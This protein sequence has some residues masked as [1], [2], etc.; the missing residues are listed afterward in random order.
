TDPAAEPAGEGVAAEGDETEAAA[1]PPPV[2]DDEPTQDCPPCKGGAPGWMAT[3]ADMATLLMSFF[4]LLLSFS[5][6]ELPKFEQINGSIKAAFGVKR[7]VPTINIP[8][9]RS[10]I[11]ENFSPALAQRTVLN[12]QQQ[13]AID[14]NAEFLIR[15]TRE[16]P[17]SSPVQADFE[18]VQAALA[19]PIERGEVQV[20]VEDETIVVEYTA[21]SSGGGAGGTGQQQATGGKLSQQLVEVA[22][23]VTQVQSEVVSE[24]QLYRLSTTT[25]AEELD[26]PALDTVASS[27]TGQPADSNRYNEI[28]AALRSEVEQ[29]LVEVEKV[30]DDV[31][32]RLASQG[33][34]LSGSAELDPGFLPLLREVGSTLVSGSGRVRVEGHTDN[35]PVAFSQQFNSNWDLSAGRSATV[36][37]FLTTELGMASD[38]LEV[39]GFAD[40]KPLESNAT[41]DGRA[42]NRRIEIIVEGS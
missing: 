23:I 2:G 27:A 37:A 30:G 22:A 41:P 24:V 28:R 5:D 26:E 16:N 13:R 36:A 3:F 25:D 15:R 6:T 17:E 4:V 35:I 38:R 10:L 11:V 31:V 8:M 39:S 21:T 14:P 29:G 9:A 32:I 33:S 12:Q 7:L 18:K 40:T 34:F 1:A 42:R 20:R 19:E